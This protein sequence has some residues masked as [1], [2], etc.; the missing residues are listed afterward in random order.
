MLHLRK[1]RG[2][3]GGSANVAD[4]SA[5]N[6]I[7]QR[8]HRFLDRRKLVEAVDLEEVNVVRAQTFERSLNLV[9][10]AGSGQAILVL[11]VL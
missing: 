9:K 3:H 1:L 2:P 6:Q 10:N 4:F 11:V 8:A 5:Q 7:V